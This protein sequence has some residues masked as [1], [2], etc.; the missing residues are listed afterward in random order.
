M[1]KR[2]DRTADTRERIERAALKHFVEQGI[3]ETSIRDIAD[4]ARISLGAMY[5]HFDSKEELAWQLFINGWNEI[6]QELRRR[7]G[8]Q[9]LLPAKM[10]S[11]IEYVFRRFDED[12]LLVTYIFSSRHEHLKRVPSTRG[13]PYTI[14]RL[15]IGEAMRRGE[16]PQGDLDLKTAL[17]VGAII[18]TIDSRIL[19]RLK[20]SLSDSAAVAADL[21]VHMLGGS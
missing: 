4:E 14:F 16:I 12:W 15:V 2:A 5:N 1:E 11:M 10:R 17:I 13:N 9:S 20:G 3:A 21:C 6:G 18:Q 19:A 8:G 7:A